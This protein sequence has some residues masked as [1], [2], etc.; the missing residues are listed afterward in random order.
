MLDCWLLEKLELQERVPS[1]QTVGGYQRRLQPIREQWLIAPLSSALQ[2]GAVNFTDHKTSEKLPHRNEPHR[3]WI[4]QKRE[5]VRSLAVFWDCTVTF[6]L[7]LDFT[8]FSRSVVRPFLIFNAS[9]CGALERVPVAQ[10]PHCCWTAGI[11]SD[12]EMTAE[13]EKKRWV[14]RAVSN[15]LCCKQRTSCFCGAAATSGSLWNSNALLQLT[16]ETLRCAQRRQERKVSC[17]LSC[18]VWEC[19]F[20]LILY[21][22]L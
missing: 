5:T 6:A 20:L 3:A 9:V 4:L 8:A 2:C 7:L 15:V 14:Q 16:P 12:R 17:I 22:L 10:R 1:A 11:A 13:K 18:W 21:R 19:C